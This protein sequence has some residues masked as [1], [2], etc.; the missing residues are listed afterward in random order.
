MTPQQ[1]K[2]IHIAARQV[3]LIDGRDDARYR[4]L[5]KSTGSV[6]SAKQ[7]DNA[8][9][10][11]VMAVME[12]MGFSRERQFHLDKA[13]FSGGGGSATKMQSTY[14]RDK[15]A[16]RGR[17]A[18]ARM[19]HLIIELAA[20]P[21]QRYELAALVSQFSA[22]RTRE[23]GKL[24]PQEAWKLIEMLKAAAARE[25]AREQ[26]PQPKLREAGASKMPPTDA[27]QMIPFGLK[28]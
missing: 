25:S 22:G 17:F 18:N 8:S 4:L 20:A 6:E 9:F 12:D 26:H 16:A 3:G 27:Q 1:L 21:A 5:L 10:E 28:L 2:L 14:W 7:L 13:S 15:V 19:L 11:D 23:V 24:T